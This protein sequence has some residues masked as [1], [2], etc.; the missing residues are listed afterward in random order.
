MHD[1]AAFQRD[2]SAA[3]SSAEV[4]GTAALAIHRNSGTR[5]AVDALA[6]NYPVVRALFGEAPFAACA[7]TYLLADPPRD[8]R[9][10]H[11]GASFAAFLGAYPPVGDMPWMADVAALER[12]WLESMFAADAAVLDG[13]ALLALGLDDRTSVALHPATRFAHFASPAASIWR[14]HDLDDPD[15]LEAIDWRPEAVIVTR[16]DQA[17]SIA[18]LSATGLAF[19]SAIAASHTTV[20][21]AE[22]ALAVDPDL[23]LPALFGGLIEAGAFTHATHDGSLS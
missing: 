17:V 5:A 3:L 6:A 2:F 10:S 1:L 23:D 7:R 13:E 12:L 16:H 21:A 20:V 14:A 4:A 8:P 18:P 9:L 19:V 22:A 11:V 15:A